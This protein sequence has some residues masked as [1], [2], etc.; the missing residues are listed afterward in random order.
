[1]ADNEKMFQVKIITPD[2]IFY[3]GE[4]EMIEFMTT[5]GQIGVYRKHIPLTTVLSPGAVII[6]EASGEKVAAV[7]AGFAEVLPDQVTLLAEI[8]EWPEEIDQSRAEAAR[9]RAEE[10]LQARNADVD[11]VRA[12]YALRKALTRIGVKD[13]K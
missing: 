1:M 10:R 12:E 5:S 8:A 13:M 11:L 9:Q 2:R 4:A 6:H 7:H 3:T